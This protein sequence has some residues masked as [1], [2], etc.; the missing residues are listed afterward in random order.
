[1]KLTVIEAERWKIDG[2][3]CF[4][5]VPKTIWSKYFQAD[6]NNLLDI[7]NRLLVVET[8]NRKILIDTGFGN[9]KD[10]KYY[11]FKYIQT[12]HTLEEALNQAGFKVEDI[13]DVIFTHLHDDHCGG[14]SI[15][16]DKQNIVPL[17][18]NAEYWITKAQWNW[19]LQPNPREKGAFFVENLTVLE[20]TGKL[21]FIE[22]E[23]FG[24][25]AI[26]FKIM[27]GHT[28]GQLIPIIK[29]KGKTI[30]YVA[31]FIP[32]IAHIPLAYIAAVDVEPLKALAEK[33]V[34]LKEAVEQDY[35]LFFEHD[36]ENQ[37]CTLENTAKGIRAKASLTL[38]VIQ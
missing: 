4:G 18:P 33:E 8:G 22:E 36:A 35:Y 32:S 30:V 23:D 25:D 26:S 31:D 20:N 1:M 29:Y 7:H 17:F 5:L 2:G 10:E 19:S 21:H 12:T 13:T 37:L 34:F 27:D 3:V 14:A 11:S 15:Y 24:T 9:K 6:E 16:D 28:K 38:D